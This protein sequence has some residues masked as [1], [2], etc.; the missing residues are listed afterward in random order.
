MV[1]NSEPRRKKSVFSFYG[2]SCVKTVSRKLALNRY[3]LTSL[4][5]DSIKRQSHLSDLQF[6][7]RGVSSL[8]IARKLVPSFPSPSPVI[9]FF[10]LVPTF[11]MNSRGN[12]CY[13]GYLQFYQAQG[14]SFLDSWREVENPGNEVERRPTVREFELYKK[15][16]HERLVKRELPSQGPHS[17]ILMTGGSEG[18]F[19]GLTFWPKGIFLGVWKTPGFYWVA[20]TTQGFF[21]GVVFFISSNQ[22]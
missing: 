6:S 5:F 7:L 3:R 13:A 4:L 9:P 15:K 20:K 12:A 19:F 17:H 21:W 8:V 16:D 18:F 10:S 22:K 14:F 11:S 2:C 1:G